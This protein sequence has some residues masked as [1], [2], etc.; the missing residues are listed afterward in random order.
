MNVTT[1][2]QSRK[3]KE[4]GAPQDTEKYWCT[5]LGELTYSKSCEAYSKATC[6]DH[7]AAYDLE[8]LIGWLGDD[9]KAL[10]RNAKFHPEAETIPWAAYSTRGE[11]VGGYFPGDS[12]IDA[13]LA[14]AEAVK[15]KGTE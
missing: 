6:G 14:L 1:F 10:Q 8:S 2:D 11:H 12:A 7:I 4:W 13:L 3:L 5:D 9:F 15:G